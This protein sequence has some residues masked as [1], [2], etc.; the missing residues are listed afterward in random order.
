M[1]VLPNRVKA[2]L[3]K[4]RCKLVKSLDIKHGLLDDLLSNGV[5]LERHYE[6]IKVHLN[7]LPQ[8]YIY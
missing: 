1:S 3:D 5:L 8:C 4:K 6:T 2:L 7:Y